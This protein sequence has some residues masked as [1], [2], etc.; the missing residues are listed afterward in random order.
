MELSIGSDVEF[1]LHHRRQGTIPATS[2]NCPGSK[3]EPVAV[4]TLGTFHRDNL[5]VELQPLPAQ[6]PSEFVGNSWS[7]YQAIKMRYSHM[8]LSLNATPVASFPRKLL[9]TLGEANEI[10]CEPDICAYTG[11]VAQATSAE[12]LGIYRTASGHIHIGGIEHIPEDRRK[13]VVKWMDVLEGLSCRNHEDRHIITPVVRRRFYGQAGRFRLKPY[14]L[15]WRT[16]SNANWW[17][18]IQD[19]KHAASLFASVYMAATLTLADITVESLASPAAIQRMRD[20]IDG[21]RRDTPIT[22]RIGY[23]QEFLS[24]NTE[25]KSVLKQAQKIY[26]AVPGLYPA[27][28]RR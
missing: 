7:L 24:E 26:G 25:Y 28:R 6:T 20:S 16:P 2:F 8:S 1:F 23:W 10:G 27:R 3:L 15:E 5:S 9:A 13:E 19:D 22:A 12:K 21:S 4:G 14:G 18:W 17:N 11:E